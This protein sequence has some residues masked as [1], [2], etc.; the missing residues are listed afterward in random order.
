MPP[1]TP[2]IRRTAVAVKTEAPQLPWAKSALASIP[3]PIIDTP[4]TAMPLAVR[5]TAPRTGRRPNFSSTSY[6]SLRGKVRTCMSVG[7]PTEGWA[8][9]L[10]D[11][12]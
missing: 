8:M 10:P 3:L 5:M 12:E 4:V 9:G 2:V 6:L 1:A 11:A 7:R